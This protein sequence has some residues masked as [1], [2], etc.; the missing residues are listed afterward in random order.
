MYKQHQR[1]VACALTIPLVQV[2]CATITAEPAFC[3]TYGA[4]DGRCS[5]GDLLNYLCSRLRGLAP[6]GELREHLDQT[7]KDVT[8]TRIENW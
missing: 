2:L 8:G 7:A 6:L 1:R 3:A 5:L 4:L